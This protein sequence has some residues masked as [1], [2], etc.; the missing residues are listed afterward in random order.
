MRRINARLDPDL[1]A[2]VEALRRRTGQSVTEIVRESL[3]RYH[4]SIIG[5]PERPFAIFQS[6][7]LVA[8]GSAPPDLSSSYKRELAR[9]LAKKA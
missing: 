3:E 8:C 6:S 7:G 4:A 5:G 2:K 1:E 9:S